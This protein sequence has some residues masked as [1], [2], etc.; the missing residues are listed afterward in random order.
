WWVETEPARG[1]RLPLNVPD[2]LTTREDLFEYL[3]DVTRGGTPEALPRKFL[4]PVESQEIWAAGVT[5]YR[6]RAARMTESESAGGGDFYDRVYSAERP[7]LFVKATPHRVV[8]PDAGIRIRRDSQW[9][10][11]EP[12]LA[13]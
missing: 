4:A 8:G 10:V 12:E 6:S 1:V 9:N 5:Y 13:L 11:P 3:E 2:S 7:E